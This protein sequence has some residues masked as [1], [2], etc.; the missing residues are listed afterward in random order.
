MPED[1]QARL[2]FATMNENEKAIDVC[3][4]DNRSD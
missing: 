2:L 1:V 4:M 3:D